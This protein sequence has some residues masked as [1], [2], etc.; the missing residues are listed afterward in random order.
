MLT[1]QFPE[2]DRQI[3]R[4]YGPY[5]ADDGAPV[6]AD[7]LAIDRK[8]KLLLGGDVTRALEEY[9]SPDPAVALPA[10]E[11]FVHA[12]CVAFGLTPFDPRTGQGT[13]ES[14]CVRTWNNYQAWVEKKNQKAGNSPTSAPPTP[15]SSPSKTSTTT[16]SAAST[17]TPS[18]C[19][20]D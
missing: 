11:Q 15:A 3:Y 10:A 5:Y 14:E 8:L 13:I 7:P 6:Y 12:I 20:C 2:A 19:G 4:V 17:S 16:P 9:H 1:K 18:G